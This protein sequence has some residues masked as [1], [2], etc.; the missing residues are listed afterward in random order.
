MS[1]FH[2]NLFLVR[3]DFS[4]PPLTPRMKQLVRRA[5]PLLRSN[6]GGAKAIEFESAN[7]RVSWCFRKSLVPS[8][9]RMLEEHTRRSIFSGMVP[10]IRS[11][12]YIKSTSNGFLLAL[13]MD[14]EHICEEGTKSWLLLRWSKSRRACFA[15]LS[16]SLANASSVKLFLP[17]SQ[18]TGKRRGISHVI[19]PT[20]TV[21]IRAMKWIGSPG[22]ARKYTVNVLLTNRAWKSGHRIRERI[23]HRIRSQQAQMLLVQASFRQ[24]VRIQ[25]LVWYE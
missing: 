18:M 21:Q 5:L 22:P 19:T 4:T 23:E 15:A 14:G 13:R 8:L 20:V 17:T 10:R 1:F 7:R 6:S 3:L 16:F 2:Q 24:E 11:Y 25:T 9:W 12:S